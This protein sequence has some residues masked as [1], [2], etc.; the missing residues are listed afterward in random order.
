MNTSCLD[1]AKAFSNA[2]GISGFEDEVLALARKFAAP[3]I[4][5]EEDK[6]RNL[7][8]RS[9]DNTGK[10][11]VV[12]IDGHSDEVG[13]MVQSINKNGTLKFIPVGGWSAQ[14]VMGQR[15]RIKSAKGGYLPGIVGAKP[16]H[17][18]KAQDKN[19]VTDI[20]E[21]FIDIGACSKEEVCEG[22][23]IEPGAPVVPDTAF[24]FDESKGMMMGKAFDCRLGCAAVID[25][26]NRLEGE[27]LNVDV[28]GTLSSQEELGLRGVQVAA[29]RVYPDVAII[30]E[31]TPADDVFKNGDSA[32]GVVKKGPQ[33]RH[34]DNAMM[35]NP[36]FV[37]FAR[38]IAKKAGIP[39]QDAVRDSGGT[40]GGM[41]TLSGRGVPVVVLGVPVRYIH[42]PHGL[43]ALEDLIAA[44]NLALEIVK[45]LDET[46]VDGF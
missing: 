18:V 42:A 31:G 15:V 33:I 6:L 25:T 26:L 45:H 43:A 41:V 21:M 44:V 27:S 30:F 38:E 22:S 35:A 4:V 39:F 46:V 1:Y 29:R 11:P 14:V 40:N 10:R 13:F 17:F 28:V 5:I 19:K 3:S 8:L 37:A 36:R 16:P 23:G 2:N 32:Q 20:A 12:M 7:Y 9:G 24:S 34:R